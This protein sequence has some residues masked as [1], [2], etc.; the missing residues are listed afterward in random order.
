MLDS[1]AHVNVLPEH[2][3]RSLQKK[4]R[5]HHTKIKLTAY[6]GGSIPVKGKCIARVSNGSNKSYSLQFIV[7]PTKST[8]LLALETCE[9][10][11][12]LNRVSKVEVDQRYSDILTH[13]KDAFGDIGCLSGYY[14]I[15]INPAVK[16]VVHPARRVPFALKNKLKAELNRM[17]SLEVIEKVDHPTDWVNSIVIVEKANG[18]IRI[19]L[20]PKDLN[21]AIKREFSQLPTAEEIMSQM[22]RAK[23]FTKLDASAGYW[24]VKL[25]NESSDLLAFNTFFGRYKFKRLPFGVHCASEVFSKRVSEIIDG[26]EGVAHIQDDII[27]WGA[28][29][30]V[31]D[32]NLRKVL[33]RIKLSGLKLNRNKCSFGI[34][35]IKYV[36]QI[37]TDKG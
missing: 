6:D 19:C 13:Y 11:N 26:L 23:I 20:D 18:D 1:G 32:N 35:E 36:G 3:Y 22:A 10:L 2:I 33:E 29:R 28:N 34:H 15:N 16:P 31:H 37:L 30:E 27:I 25:D 9:K 12:L 7:V 21:R 14:H 4:P 17:V 24:Q 5:W 8:P